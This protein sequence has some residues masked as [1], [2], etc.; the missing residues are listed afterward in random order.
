VKKISHLNK[1]YQQT[2]S[3]SDPHRRYSKYWN[4]WQ[5]EMTKNTYIRVIHDI[6]YL[7][8]NPKNINGSISLHWR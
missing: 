1:I 5:L 3:I 4:V 2:S 6:I 7:C 8:M